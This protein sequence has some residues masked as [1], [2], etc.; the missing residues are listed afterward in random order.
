MDMLQ[1]KGFIAL[2][3]LVLLVVASLLSRKSVQTERVIAATPAAI[4]SILMDTAAYSDWNPV[5]IKVDGTLAEGAKMTNLVQ[6]P[7]A[8]AVEMGSTVKKLIAE[9]ELNQFGG[10]PGLLTFSHTYKL[11][12]V[13][14]GTRVTQHEVYR[15]IGVWFWDES[16]VEPA[17]SSVNEALEKRVQE[18]SLSVN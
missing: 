12:P 11:E 14:G 8:A 10:L 7:G 4:W 2:A 6:E 9:Q 5:L 17:Y 18:L 3:V 16:W 15:G 1:S 13:E